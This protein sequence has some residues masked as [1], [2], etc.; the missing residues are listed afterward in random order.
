M[1]KL[2]L[3]HLIAL[4]TN[5]VVL[6]FNV[7]CI[8]K[9]ILM[10]NEEKISF[11]SN[12]NFII[13]LINKTYIDISNYLNNK[14]IIINNTNETKPRKRLKLYSVDLFNKAIHKR[15]LETR[16]EDKFIIEYNK[17]N[18]DYLIFNVF[19]NQHNNPKYKNAIKIGVLTENII[20]N[21][22]EVDY[23]LGHGSHK[24]FG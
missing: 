22:N 20:P 17:D 11:K 21:L 16:L 5:C 19:G 2:K 7:I 23:A 8:L 24:L 9:R 12:D 6:I 4:I 14:Y 13:K 10:N 18:P 3:T 1:A 15:W